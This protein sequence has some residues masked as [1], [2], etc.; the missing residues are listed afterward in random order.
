MRHQEFHIG[1]ELII[2]SNIRTQSP[3]GVVL[4]GVEGW[5][6]PPEIRRKKIERIFGD[7]DILSNQATFGSRKFSVK[8]FAQFPSSSSIRGFRTNLMM[9]GQRINS[10][11]TCQ[12]VYFQNG[13]EVFREKIMARPE[14][15]FFPDWDP[16]ENSVETTLEFIA[17]NPWKTVFQNGATEPEAQKR[18]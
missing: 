17:A 14:D 9:I 12:M 7:G 3:F 5:D 8:I 16:I 6:T 18:L 1:N 15:G 10:D 13:I 2:A 4:T 11:T